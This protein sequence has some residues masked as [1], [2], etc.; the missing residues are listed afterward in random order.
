MKDNGSVFIPP[1]HRPSDPYITGLIGGSIWTGNVITYAFPTDPDDYTGYPDDGQPSYMQAMPA[2]FKTAAVYWMNQIATFTSLSFVPGNTASATLRWGWD[3]KPGDGTGANFAG[4]EPYA[5]DAWFQFLNYSAPVAGDGISRVIAHELG[6]QMG[7]KHPNDP[8]GGVT[9]PL[10]QDSLAYTVMSYNDIVNPQ[11]GDSQYYNSNPQSYMTL[12]IQVLQT[13][14][15]A[16]FTYNSGDTVYTFEAA[17]GEMRLNGVGQGAPAFD[18]VYRTIWDGGGNDTY[19]F[20]TYANDQSIDL[21]PGAWSIFSTDLLAPVVDRLGEGGLHHSVYADGNIA[22]ALQY[23]GDARSLIENAKTG[24]GNDTIKGN[25]ADNI[26]DG[27]AGDD[28]L[29]G[30][31]GNDTLMG[32]DGNDVLNSGPGSDTLIGGLGNDGYY[33]LGNDETIAENAGAGT[34]YIRVA[35]DYTLGANF[36]NLNLD[37]DGNINGTGNALDNVLTGTSGNNRLD[38]GEGVDVLI[39]FG[40]DDTYVL[41]S[42]YETVREDANGGT[43][44]VIASATHTL[45]ANVENLTL[46]DEGIYNGT[47]NALNNVI[48]GNIYSNTLVGLDGNDVLIGQLGSDVMIGGRGND[49]YYV[50]NARDLVSEA[51]NEGNDLVISS[52]A[53]TLTADVEKLTLTGEGN[54]A[55]TGNELNNTIIGN[56]GNNKLSGGLGDDTLGGGFGNDTLD[57]GKGGDNMKGGAGDDRYYIDNKL[58]TVTEYGNSG[59]DTVLINGTYTL[60]QNVENLLFTGAGDRFG[61]GNALDNHITGNTGDNTL[62]GADGNDVIDGGAGGDTMRGGTGNDIF[63]VDNTGDTVT[64]YSGQGTDSVVSTVSFML[65]NNVE[66]L[67]LTELAA[68][69]ATGNSRDNILLGNAGKNILNGMAGSDTLTGGAGADTFVFSAHSGADTITDFSASAGDRI[70]VSAYT[71]GTAHTAFISQNGGNTVID[72]GGGNV[73]TIQNTTATDANFLTHIT[74]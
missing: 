37:G 49:T 18:T 55:G 70:D 3:A 19:D 15:G 14:Y 35:H 42:F 48:S 44:L 13:L 8:L 72:L 62:G 23:Q 74:W 36:E 53:Y 21:N 7:L 16:N 71:H 52:R 20:S 68:V 34:D 43:D 24:D 2:S 73:I 47:G 57:G 6:H 31:A 28:S 56:V 39:G 1:N 67:T 25:N 60:G 32:G 40:G 41:D 50:D 38:G 59:M 22:N 33:L 4:P 69:N 64:E 29:F 9:V 46:T 45:E 63:Y 30:N 54:Y 10:D 61:T 66:N 27:G 17:T 11:A 51:H 26:L 12:D 58:D 65:G 5:G